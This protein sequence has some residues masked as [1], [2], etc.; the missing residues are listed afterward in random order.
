V[1]TCHSPQFGNFSPTWSR[2]F[3]FG[4]V[5][6]RGNTK[7]TFFWRYPQQHSPRNQLLLSSWVRINKGDNPHGHTHF[8]WMRKLV[9]L[10]S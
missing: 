9:T 6:P 3:F 5:G 8:S 2:A 4:R 10:A 1:K 7:I